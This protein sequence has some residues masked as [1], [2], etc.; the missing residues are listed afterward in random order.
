MDAHP[1]SV[2]PCRQLKYLREAVGIELGTHGM[3]LIQKA[4]CLLQTSLE[5]RQLGGHT[6]RWNAWHTS[7]LD[8]VPP[9]CAGLATKSST[10]LPVRNFESF[11]RISMPAASLF[12]G[13]FF[14]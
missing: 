11:H 13:W 14:S 7:D 3:R 1:F 8:V 5:Y 9:Q 6:R 10:K 12:K 2:R 4:N